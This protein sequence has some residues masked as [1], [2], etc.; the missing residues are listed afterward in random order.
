MA[1]RY[2]R[3]YLKGRHFKLFTDNQALTYFLSLTQPKGRLARW[4]SEILQFS[5]D[6]THRPGE[7]L[8]DADALS[9]R[10]IPK[11]TFTES[12]HHAR[13]WE[14][15]QDIEVQ[16]RNRFMCQSPVCL[17][18]YSFTMTVRDQEDMTDFGE[19]FGN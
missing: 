5:F 4:I 8:P 10:H 17:Q 14:G 16:D 7:K 15:T 2:F 9:R 13:I 11:D 6:V 18:S 19:L 1:L 3:S 12:I